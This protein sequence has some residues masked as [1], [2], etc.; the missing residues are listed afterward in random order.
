MAEAKTKIG[1]AE[2]TLTW[3]EDIAVMEKNHRTRA[4]RLIDAFRAA[5]ENG[6]PK[7]R[8]TRTRRERPLTPADDMADAISLRK[9]E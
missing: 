1:T 2:F 5:G 8:K 3:T 7:E 6:V 4:L 9:S